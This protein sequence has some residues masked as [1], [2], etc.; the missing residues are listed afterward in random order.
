MNKAQEEMVGE[1]MS[2]MEGLQQLA[3]WQLALVRD[4]KGKLAGFSAL[5]GGSLKRAGSGKRRGRRAK[6]P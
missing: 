5:T 4:V 2:D 3:S 1:L 6:K